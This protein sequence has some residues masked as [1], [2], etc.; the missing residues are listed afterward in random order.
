M[1]SK[2]YTRKIVEDLVVEGVDAGTV[3]HLMDIAAYAIERIA[4]TLARSA[5]FEL[6][7][8]ASAERQGVAGFALSLTRDGSTDLEMWVAE[9]TAGDGHVRALLTAEQPD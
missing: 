8:F 6:S 7:D 1:M 2:R 3:D 4:P 9:F 5:C